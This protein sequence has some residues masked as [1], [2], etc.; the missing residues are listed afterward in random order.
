MMHGLELLSNRHKMLK[1]KTYSHLILKK[2]IIAN[3]ILTQIWKVKD[4]R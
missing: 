3:L 4:Q 1:R 2:E